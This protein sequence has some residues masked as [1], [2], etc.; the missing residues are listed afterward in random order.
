MNIFS[1]GRPPNLLRP[2]MRS[3]RRLEAL[4]HRNTRSCK[5]IGTPTAHVVTSPTFSK[6][7]ASMQAP[8]TCSFTCSKEFLKFLG[9]N[10]PNKNHHA[11]GDSMCSSH[12]N[13]QQSL[14][15]S[16]STFWQ[17]YTHEVPHPPVEVVDVVERSRVG[18]PGASD[19][20]ERLRVRVG[21]PEPAL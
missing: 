5:S 11:P 17:Q 19:G 16:S 7:Q 1:C 2:L 9:K 10:D 15:V 12:P 6:R 20:L 4:G 18:G 8:P 14:Y 13:Q 3:E 21:A